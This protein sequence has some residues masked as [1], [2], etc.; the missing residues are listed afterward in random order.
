MAVSVGNTANS[1]V[2]TTE[3]TATF[4]LNNNKTDVFVCVSMRFLRTDGRTCSGVTFDGTSMTSDK[5]QLQ[6]PGGNTQDIRSYIFRLQ[7]AST[8]SKNVVVTLSG[9]CTC[10]AAMAICASGLSTSGQPEVTGGAGGATPSQPTV[11]ITTTTADGLRIDGLYHKAGAGV[12]LTASNS[13]TIDVQLGVNGGSDRTVL[14]HIIYNSSGAKASGYNCTTADDWVEV[15]A[16]YKMA[17]AAASG[18]GLIGNDSA[19]VGDSV[20]VGKSVLVG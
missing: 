5:M 6:Q 12:D 2:K 20:L 7:S 15:S 19:L 18:D 3:T 13:Q 16:F 8:G 1:G 14:A 10:W 17:A 9:A 11:S 4:A